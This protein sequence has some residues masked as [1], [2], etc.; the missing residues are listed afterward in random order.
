MNDERKDTLSVNRI[1]HLG[2]VGLVVTVGLAASSGAA[3]A[4][5][6]ESRQATDSAQASSKIAFI[7]GLQADRP[8]A[9]I[10]VMNVDGS[11]KRLLTR[12]TSHLYA[13]SPDGRKIA[14][15][16]GATAT[17]TSRHERRRERAAEPH[18]HAERAQPRCCLVARRA[19]DRLHE[20]QPVGPRIR[21][22]RHECRR[23]REAEADAQHTATS[24]LP[25]RPTGG[26][27]PSM[28]AARIHVMNADGSGKRLLT[29]NGA[30]ATPSGRQTGGRSPSR[31]AT[32]TAWTSTS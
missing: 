29:R 7:R 23:E 1:R 21:D 26:R 24:I 5:A 27:S 32:A 30:T 28:A 25:G 13:W 18:A 10:Y 14:F 3:S 22:L 8:P 6:T 19:E 16:R 4:P 11:G 15:G 17:T 9:E 2:A 20:D 12:N 31:A